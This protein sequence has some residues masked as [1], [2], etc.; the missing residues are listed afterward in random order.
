LDVGAI[1][2][3]SSATLDEMNGTFL[4]G[5]LLVA[6]VAGFAHAVTKP[7]IL[8]VL[9]SKHR[10]IYETIPIPDLLDRTFKGS[11]PPSRFMMQFIATGKFLRL[12]DPALSALCIVDAVFTMIF[13]LASLLVL[14][15][16]L[17]VI[18]R[19]G[20]VPAWLQHV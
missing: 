14:I 18:A 17:I 10:D 3:R 16:S 4:I 20:E 1:P 12:R 8:F 19:W 13:A 2:R 5:L 15:P 11:W 7:L 9:K 6:M